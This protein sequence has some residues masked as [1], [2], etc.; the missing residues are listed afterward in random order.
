MQ[1]GE[2]T[3]LRGVFDDSCYEKLVKMGGV[4]THQLPRISPERAEMLKADESKF[5][6]L[7]KEMKMPPEA[8]RLSLWLETGAFE[9]LEKGYLRSLCLAIYRTGKELR[10]EGGHGDQ[11][12]VDQL[13]KNKLLEAFVF[14]FKYPSKGEV[15]V[16]LEGDGKSKLSATSIAQSAF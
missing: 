13:Q 8:L 7:S 5:D 16:E 12:S 3:Y 15:A 10:S 4:R 6:E 9:A 1:V 14:K 11:V 2:L